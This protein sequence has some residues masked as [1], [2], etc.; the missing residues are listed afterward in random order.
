MDVG[1]GQLA[2]IMPYATAFKLLIT[3]ITAQGIGL[4]LKRGLVLRKF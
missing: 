3:P 4:R 1:G 2:S